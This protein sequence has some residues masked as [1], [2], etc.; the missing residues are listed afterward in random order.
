VLA[1]AVTRL[2][3][4]AGYAGWGSGQLAAEIAEGS[5]YVVDSTTHDIFDENPAGMW[6]SVLRR[7]PGELAWMSTKPVDPTMN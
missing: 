2:R 7:Q 4:F 5:W 3:V 6:G 1:P